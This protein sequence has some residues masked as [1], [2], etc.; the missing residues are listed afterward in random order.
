MTLFREAL[1]P[2]PIAFGEGMYGDERVM[3]LT[4][5]S[6]SGS[7]LFSIQYRVCSNAS[8]MRGWING[9]STPRFLLDVR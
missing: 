9:H 1:G 3:K 5:I 2:A 8:C 4:A 6:S 7:V